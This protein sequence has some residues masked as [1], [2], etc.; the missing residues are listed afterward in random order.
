MGC[1]CMSVCVCLCVCACVCYA[2]SICVKDR[3][4]ED[5]ICKR[6]DIEDV[7]DLSSN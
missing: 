3:I 5:N 1:V 6:Q 2:I 7:S 4:E